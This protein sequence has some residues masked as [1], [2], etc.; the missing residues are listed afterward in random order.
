VKDDVKYRR[1][2][3]YYTLSGGRAYSYRNDRQKNT[4]P[5]VSKFVRDV[6]NRG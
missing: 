3:A 5:H 4:D 2:R 6:G 1:C